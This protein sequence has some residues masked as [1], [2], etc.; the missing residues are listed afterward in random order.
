MKSPWLKST[1]GATSF[2]ISKAR[3]KSWMNQRVVALHEANNAPPLARSRRTRAA[4]SEG[5]KIGPLVAAL[6][7]EETLRGD[8]HPKHSG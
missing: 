8:E 2:A 3:L 4:G 1:T 5:T 6:S 7:R